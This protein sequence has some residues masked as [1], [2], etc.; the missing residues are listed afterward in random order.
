M[1]SLKL[2]QMSLSKQMNK[3]IEMKN[4]CS[5]SNKSKSEV[6]RKFTRAELRVKNDIMEFQ[7]KRTTTGKYQVTL[8][9]YIISESGNEC[10]INVE[11]KNYFVICIVFGKEYPF[12]PPDITYVSGSNEE[13]MDMF[14]IEMKLKL[15]LLQRVEWKPILSLNSVLF[16]IELLLINKESIV[17][18]VNDSDC[19][20]N[21]MEMVVTKRKMKEYSEWNSKLTT[22][23]EEDESVNES[24]D[25]SNQWYIVYQMENLKMKSDGVYKY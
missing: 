24:F 4:V 6:S 5:I 21:E 9:N 22:L 18:S 7:T 2:T 15:P 10:V 19:E 3:D 12:E 1:I 17:S 11:F 25:Q 23:I 13:V 16:S 14:D 20:T 8:S